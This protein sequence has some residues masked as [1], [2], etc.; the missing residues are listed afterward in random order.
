MQCMLLCTSMRGPSQQ[1][2]PLWPAPHPC[3]ATFIFQNPAIF[4]ASSELGDITGLY[5]IDDEGT[6]QV[7]RCDWPAG[8]LGAAPT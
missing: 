3:A 4:E 6:I 7:G 5:L 1:A 2:C 8:G